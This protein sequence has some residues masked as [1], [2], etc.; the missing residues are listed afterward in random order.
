VSPAPSQRTICERALDDSRRGRPPQG[1]KTD[2][3]R[4]DG[5]ALMQTHQL[6]VGS[7][8]ISMWM[9]GKRSY[10]GVVWQEIATAHPCADYLVPFS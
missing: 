9:M 5:S 4:R 3:L 7:M 2:A 1:R 6:L 10:K 8:R